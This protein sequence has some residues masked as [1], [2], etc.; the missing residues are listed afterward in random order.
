M[1]PLKIANQCDEAARCEIVTTRVA[2]PQIPIRYRI[3]QLSSNIEAR[4]RT[5]L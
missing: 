4:E 1:H 2:K 3:A 5:K